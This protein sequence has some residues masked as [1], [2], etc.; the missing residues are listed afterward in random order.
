MLIHSNNET[1]KK[2]GNTDK[3]KKVFRVHPYVEY[4]EYDIS[5]K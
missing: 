5:K 1:D 2:K 3:L 4:N